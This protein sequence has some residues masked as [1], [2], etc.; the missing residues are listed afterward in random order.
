MKVGDLVEDAYSVVKGI[1][2]KKEPD[3]HLSLTGAAFI[4]PRYRYKITWFQ[5]AT[6]MRLE[7]RQSWRHGVDLILLSKI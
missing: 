1:I 5:P 4:E 6:E 7:T 2:I 3:P